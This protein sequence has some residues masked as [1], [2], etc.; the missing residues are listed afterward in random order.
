MVA[1]DNSLYEA[2]VRE[3]YEEIG[4]TLER[5]EYIGKLTPLYIQVSNFKVTPF[6]FYV[7]RKLHFIPDPKEVSYLIEFGLPLLLKN[8]SIKRTQI[9]F[10]SYIVDTPYFDIQ[11]EVVWGATSMILS[12]FREILQRIK[13]EIPDLF[14]LG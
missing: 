8:E 10:N 13:K 11:N 7:K 6:V 9:S 12:E 1:E 14:N 5:N 3:T 2:S 4:I